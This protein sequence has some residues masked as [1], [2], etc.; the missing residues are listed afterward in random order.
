MWG[1]EPVV[2]SLDPGSKPSDR[3]E[4]LRLIVEEIQ[5]H[6]EFHLTVEFRE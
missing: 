2:E 3:I 6:S 1:V 5:S 4:K